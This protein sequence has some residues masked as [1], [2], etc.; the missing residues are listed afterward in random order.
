MSSSS[1]LASCLAWSASPNLS[2]PQFAHLL[3]EVLALEGPRDTS[4]SK[5]ACTPEDTA[6]TWACVSR[7][8]A[9]LTSQLSN[10]HY[11]P[12]LQLQPAPWAQGGCDPLGPQD[13][14]EHG[15]D[16]G[17][18]VQREVVAQVPLEVVPQPPV[19]HDLQEGA[20]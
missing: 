6:P 15:V 20:A 7:K 12:M 3:N 16:N 8:E 19:E 10:Q 11:R 1:A 4:C 2:A 18:V 9:P 14:P 17:S 5:A 13:E